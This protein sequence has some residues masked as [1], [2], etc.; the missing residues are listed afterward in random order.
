MG[1]LLP[2]MV[3]TALWFAG[4]FALGFWIWG[5]IEYLIHGILSHRFKTPV[6]K[7]HW[8]HHRN[9]R[10]VFTSPLAALIVSPLLWF[11]FSFLVDGVNAAFIILG[12]LL[13]FA[14]YEYTHWYI[15]FREPKTVRQRRLRDHHLA[16][17]FCNAR[18]Y[19]G[20]T[21]HFWDK[22]FRTL[23][24]AQLQAEHYAKASKTPVMEG[25]SNLKEVYSL[26]GLKM[27]RN[28]FKSNTP[29]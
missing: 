20:V 27:L 10:R 7:M 28:T 18:L 8:E 21:T 25:Q 4:F 17:H 16:H 23:P 29:K 14:H 6:A 9:P 3:W 15:H 1:T 13:G 11:G 12:V 24:D 2:E 5:F 22:V 26:Q 19:H